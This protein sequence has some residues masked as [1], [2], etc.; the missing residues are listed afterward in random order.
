MSS[1]GHMN[2]QQGRQHGVSFLADR[3]RSRAPHGSPQNVNRL[4]A[5]T[6]KVPGGV[7]QAACIKCKSILVTEKLLIKIVSGAAPRG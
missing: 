4:T 3:R 6:L 2:Y 7:P 5:G 1:S